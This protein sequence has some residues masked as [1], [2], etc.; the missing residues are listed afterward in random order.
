MT[1]KSL[2]G[3]YDLILHDKCKS[4]TAADRF[5]VNMKAY[6]LQNNPEYKGLIAASIYNS[7]TVNFSKLAHIFFTNSLLFKYSEKYG[8]AGVIEVKY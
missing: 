2:C 5:Q 8:E 7:K 1:R 3:I 4:P 6:V